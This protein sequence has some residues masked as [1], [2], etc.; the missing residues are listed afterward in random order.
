MEKTSKKSKNDNKSKIP[1]KEETEITAPE[2]TLAYFAGFPPYCKVSKVHKIFGLRP[3]NLKIQCDKYEFPLPPKSKKSRQPLSTT[4]LNIKVPELIL[5]DPLSAI[6]DFKM[7]FFLNGNGLLRHNR[8]LFFISIN[9][10]LI[11]R[12]QIFTQFDII[13]FCFE[14]TANF[15][16]L[17]CKGHTGLEY[18]W[19]NSS[20]RIIH[21]GPLSMISGENTISAMTHSRLRRR[22]VLLLLNDDR[23]VKVQ[24]GEGAKS[25]QLAY[26]GNHDFLIKRKGGAW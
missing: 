24:M 23:V 5:R 12:G 25:C 13:D 14:V 9:H 15:C 3:K 2:A 7:D 18:F 11:K 16:L 26:P 4:N 19:V 8:S 17:I 6:F 10:N 22:H 1:R 21:R 20:Y